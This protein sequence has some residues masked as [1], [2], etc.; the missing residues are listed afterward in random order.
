MC[1]CVCVRED[2]HT[3]WIGLEAQGL[4][5]DGIQTAI[6]T[7]HNND[8]KVHSI[9]R[10][11]MGELVTALP[12]THTQKA[13]HTLQSPKIALSRM[14]EMVCILQLQSYKYNRTTTHTME[15]G[16]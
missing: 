9:T 1:V 10:E 2:L 8:I 13:V 14:K 3:L 6:D 11:C 4:A 12:W 5:S 15:E 16:L 7:M